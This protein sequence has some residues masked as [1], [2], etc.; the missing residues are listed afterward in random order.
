MP[1]SLRTLLE[2][3]ILAGSVRAAARTCRQLVDNSPGAADPEPSGPD[4]CVVVV[5]VGGV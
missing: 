2:E 4:W 5:L 1:A 3:V